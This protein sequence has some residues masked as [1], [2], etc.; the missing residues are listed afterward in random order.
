MPRRGLHPLS[1]RSLLPVSKTV[2]QLHILLVTFFHLGLSVMVDTLPFVVLYVSPKRQH[3]VDRLW[4][5]R[6]SP[7]L[8]VGVRPSTTQTIGET[9]IRKN[10]G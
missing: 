9:K 1:V 7:V 4:Y 2:F 6:P 3:R 5:E 10:I 8:A